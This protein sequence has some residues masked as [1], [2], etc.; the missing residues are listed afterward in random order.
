[1]KK[2]DIKNG[3][4]VKWGVDGDVYIVNDI[5]PRIELSGGGE[6]FHVRLADVELVCPVEERHDRKGE[7]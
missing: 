1:M 7:A 4:I 5:T 2:E 3:D 6:H